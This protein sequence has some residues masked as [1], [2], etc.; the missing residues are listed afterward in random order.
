MNRLGRI[1][2]GGRL[3]WI[4]LSVAVFWIGLSAAV[5]AQHEFPAELVDFQAHP[6]NP[7]FEAAGEGNWDAQIRERGWILFDPEAPAGQPAWRMWYTGY[8]GTREGLKQLGLA[9]SRDGVHWERHPEIHSPV[10]T[11]SK[12]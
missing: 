6:A 8:D 2:G 12:T 10:P 11:G 1:I 7:L 5:F 4:G 3:L 9:T